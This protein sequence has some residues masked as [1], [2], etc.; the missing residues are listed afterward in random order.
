MSDLVAICFKW[1]SMTLCRQLNQTLPF[2]L[3]QSDMDCLLD[4]IDYSEQIYFDL[5]GNLDT[6]I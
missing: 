1:H 4:L 6:N 5:N 3:L 2:Y